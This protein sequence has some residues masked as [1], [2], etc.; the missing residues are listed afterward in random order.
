[1][2]QALQGLPG[3]RGGGDGIGIGLGLQQLAQARAQH[4]AMH[5]NNGL[6]L[7]LENNGLMRQFSVPRSNSLDEASLV[8]NGGKKT[9][10]RNPLS[11]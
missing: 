1:M 8:M 5:N 6:L 2:Q 7:N 4:V 9:L 3:F 10:P 11:L